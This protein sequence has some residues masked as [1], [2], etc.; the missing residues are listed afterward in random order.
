MGLPDASHL[1]FDR[2]E[3]IGL[4]YTIPDFGPVNN[5]AQKKLLK[6]YFKEPD[7]EYHKQMELV[8]LP[9]TVEK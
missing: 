7:G 6:E 9:E 8:K 5:D 3:K 2:D 1:D 4:N